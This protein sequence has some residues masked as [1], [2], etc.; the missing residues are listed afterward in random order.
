MADV[1]RKMR[2]DFDAS[3]V[4]VHRGSKGAVREN[5]LNGYLKKYLP[6]TVQAVGNGEVIDTLG[7]C[8]KQCDVLIVDPS[9]PPLFVGDGDEVPH[10]LR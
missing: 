7:G 9:A 2:H 3:K 1:A 10:C 6:A 8:S 4:V 5:Y